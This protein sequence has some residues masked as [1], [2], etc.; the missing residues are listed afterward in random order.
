MRINSKSSLPELSEERNPLD[1]QFFSVFRNL[2][3]NERVKKLC[4]YPGL[5]KPFEFLAVLKYISNRE[6][7]LSLLEKAQAFYPSH[8]TICEHL[9][10]EYIV[11]EKWTHAGAFARSI[12]RPDGWGE[13]SSFAEKCFAICRHNQAFR[14]FMLLNGC[15]AE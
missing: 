1:S 3:L 11:Q 6:V 8:E 14:E 2:M 5:Y 9:L 7:K 13:N 4:A 12:F 15:L 10:E